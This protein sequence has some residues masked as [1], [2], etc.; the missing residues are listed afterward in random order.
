[1]KENGF[2]ILNSNPGGQ[3][4][5]AFK[6]SRKIIAFPIYNSIPSPYYF[7]CFKSQGRLR[8]FSDMQGLKYLYPIPLPQKVLRT[9]VKTW[10]KSRKGIPTSPTREAE[11]PGMCPGPGCCMLGFGRGCLRN[12]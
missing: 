1:M 9:L 2:R 7:Y 12:W 6:F 4:A 11:N 5:I 3:M 10:G 8:T